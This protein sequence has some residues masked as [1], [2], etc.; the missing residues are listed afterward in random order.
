MDPSE[1]EWFLKSLPV[2]ARCRLLFHVVHH[3]HLLLIWSKHLE[4]SA[5]TAQVVHGA[6]DREVNYHLSVVMCY[7][8][9]VKSC[10]TH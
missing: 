3:V 10:D 5:V 9:D 8:N 6:N 7:G 4:A 2:L 1:C